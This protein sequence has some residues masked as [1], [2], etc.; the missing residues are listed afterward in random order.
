MRSSYNGEAISCNRAKTILPKLR[1]SVA[2]TFPKDIYIKKSKCFAMINISK[3]DGL[4]RYL[5]K[6]LK[7]YSQDFSALTHLH[8]H[9]IIALLAMTCTPTLLHSC[10]PPKTLPILAPTH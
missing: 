10:A 4:N 9:M 5:H 6:R 8:P 1:N 3:L 7:S 2:F